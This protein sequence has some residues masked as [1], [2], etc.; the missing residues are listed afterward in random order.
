MCFLHF[1]L[2]VCAVARFLQVVLVIYLPCLGLWSVFFLKWSPWS[3]AY[4][5]S[6]N[7][8]L[9][10]RFMF[11]GRPCI[12]PCLICFSML[13]LNKICST[14]YNYIYISK[15]GVFITLRLCFASVSFFLVLLW[16]YCAR[17]AHW[18]SEEAEGLGGRSASSPVLATT[19]DM[20]T[21]SC[22]SSSWL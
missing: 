5:R 13:L 11:L 16:S 21:A 19:T 15:F 6:V 8:C 22:G 3:L 10:P 17:N 2:I 18:K 4:A 20:S 7:F 1:S 9:F 12:L 14:S